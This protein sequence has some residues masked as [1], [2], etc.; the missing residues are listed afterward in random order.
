MNI[1]K[2]AEIAGVSVATISRVLNHPE[3]V[4]PE[5]RDRVLAVMKEQNYTPNWFA[6]GLN[7]GTNKTIALLVPEIESETQQRI[8]SG[9]ETVARN[10][11]YAVFFCNTHG[12]AQIEEESLQMCENRQVDGI[13]LVSSNLGR[14]RV[15]QTRESGIPCV[16][17]GKNR[18]SGCDTLC[19]IDF[20]E[21]AYRLTR[22]LLSFGYYSIGLVRNLAERNM[23]AQMEAGFASA[24]REHQITVETKLYACEASVLNGYLFAQQL[25]QQKLL[26]QALITA[27]D[28]QALGIMKAAQDAN[29][30]VPQKLA[31]ASMTDSPVCG[32]VNPPIT[33]LELPASKLGM[34]AG[35]L[36][37]DSIEN[38]ELELGVPQEMVL[39]PKLKIRRSCGNE[40]YIYELFD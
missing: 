10:K 18:V 5:T 20:E 22:H 25:I 19:Y 21:G 27:G 38:K 3:Q 30:I 36:L 4:L 32:L 37:F 31:L 29:I 6:R 16:Y 8:I 39:Q 34:A 13:A 15:L 2:V 14:D 12:N 35:R 26:P 11:E 1:R 7:L 9:I 40:K 23:S 28:G 17:V 33:A 24:L